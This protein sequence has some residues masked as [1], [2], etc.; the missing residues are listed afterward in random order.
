MIRK[1]AAY[2]VLPKTISSFERDYL[3]R[4][5]R[6]ALWFFL[7]HPPVLMAVAYLCDTNLRSALVL[8][9]LT[10][11][12]PVAAYRVLH[13]PRQIS[14]IFGL[15]SVFMGGLLVHFGQGVMQIEMHFYFF[16]SLAL[17]AVFA[18]P[19]VIIV[20]A[21]AVALHHLILYF[22]FPS[23]VFNYEASLVAVA[24]HALFVILESIAACFV[25]R[26]FF[27]SVVGLEKV[28]QELDRK[29]RDLGL[30]LDNV[31]QG[32]LYADVSGQL[33]SERALI[34]SRWLGTF[35]P[36][37]RIWDYF[38]W[39]Q[40]ELGR[41]LR[42]GWESLT[43]GFLPPEVAI[44]QFP[45]RTSIG[46]R[47]LS[48]DYKLIMKN[49]QVCSVLVIVSDL[50]DALERER[51]EANQREMVAIFR[52][53]N[54][55]P[56]GFAEFVGETKQIVSQLTVS[57][58]SSIVELKRGVHTLKGNA[59]LF[60]VSSLVQV[61]HHLEGRLADE[62]ELFEPSEWSKLHLAWQE[63]EA[64]IKTLSR[65]RKEGTLEVEESEYQELLSSLSAGA[66]RE[67]L[68]RIIECWRHEP[69]Q[70]RLARVAE[71]AKAVA[72]RLGKP[73]LK[74]TCHADGVRFQNE[75]W[76]E[77]WPAF[78]HVVRNAVD[79]GIEAAEERQKL[80]KAPEGH[81]TLEVR[82]TEGNVELSLADDG[83]GIQ[84]DRVRAAAERTHLKATTHEELVEAL[85]HD[86][87][88]TK[89]HAN[90]YSGRGI[91]MGAVRKACEKM[92]GDIQVSSQ[93]GAGTLIRFRFPK[94]VVVPAFSG[95]RG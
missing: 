6:I 92:K 40:P 79:H 68:K 58:P 5:N 73:G 87:L 17:L 75:A 89:E 76:Q 90:E 62:G 80:G 88:S 9:L 43:D 28:A 11:A 57:S 14:M 39:S 38:G 22:I 71:Q 50:T 23:S 32:F 60:G 72:E 52:H 66:T 19:V 48:L 70:A 44:D 36:G 64:K 16:V 47:A 63:L 93:Q 26:S 91:G 27:E 12:G 15:T 45:K 84:W 31:G 95:P 65:E 56:A 18:N 10:L 85:F 25:A 86:G 53:I 8:S 94:E 82:S 74:V 13:N 61:C 3:A 49:E 77:F 54:R 41:W 37:T 81:L 33:S 55:D 34:L 2:L 20:A 67:E 29:N 24:I 69:A 51:S 4:M 30:V 1:L 46:G 35:E 42:L 7:V 83:H 59:S 21:G 78:A